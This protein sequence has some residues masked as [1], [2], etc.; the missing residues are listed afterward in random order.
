[1]NGIASVTPA[2]VIKVD[3]IE[4]GQH[5]IARLVRQHVIVGNSAEVCK[6]VVVDIHGEA[7]FNGLL[8]K[9]V[10]YSIRFTT[11]RRTEYDGGTE[12]I[13]HIDPAFVPFLFVV[14]T[15]RQID[16]ILVLQQT[17]F[18]HEGFILIIEY[19]IHEVVLE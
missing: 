1:M 18:L 2:R 15:G 3:D 5:F 6:L 16:G 11:T 7:F 13:D 19:I 10:H 14:E 12:R 9:V 4:L 8:D 17:C